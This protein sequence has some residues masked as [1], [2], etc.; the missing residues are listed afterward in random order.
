MKYGYEKISRKQKSR[1]K[2]LGWLCIIGLCF[3]VMWPLGLLLLMVTFACYD[4]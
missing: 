4:Y 1:L 2:W 3:G